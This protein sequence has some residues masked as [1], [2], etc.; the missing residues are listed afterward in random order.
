MIQNQFYIK[1][2]VVGIVLM[3]EGKY[4]HIWMEVVW[5]LLLNL[6]T[7]D[8][9]FAAIQIIIVPN[10]VLKIM[11]KCYVGHQLIFQIQFQTNYLLLRSNQMVLKC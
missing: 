1:Q 4:V 3:P 8:M 7:L 2:E 11:N 5:L 9:E 6:A 10:V